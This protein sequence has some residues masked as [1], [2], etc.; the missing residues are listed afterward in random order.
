MLECFVDEHRLDP[1]ADTYR[2]ILDK[3]AYLFGSLA[4]ISA[5]ITHTDEDN[6]ANA[7]RLGMAYYKLS[8]VYLDVNQYQSGDSDPWNVRTLMTKDEVE[9]FAA[10]LK[11]TATGCLDEFPERRVTRLRPLIG[12]DVAAWSDEL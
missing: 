2:S 8:Q 5:I 9:S 10:R 6:V 3:Q 7:A 11:E 1:S 4:G 12:L